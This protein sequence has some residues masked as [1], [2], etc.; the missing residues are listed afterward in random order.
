MFWPSQ[1]TDG[2]HSG[3]GHGQQE[4]T[5]SPSRPSLPA[6]R[7]RARLLIGYGR[8]EVILLSIEPA[9]PDGPVGRPGRTNPVAEGHCED[10]NPEGDVGDNAEALGAELARGG[11]LRYACQLT[12][13]G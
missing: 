4:K 1:R 13:V 11:Y 8:R 7:P 9:Q 6:G 5:Q 10:G 2:S 12:V 3:S